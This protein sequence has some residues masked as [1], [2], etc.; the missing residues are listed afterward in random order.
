[1]C[2]PGSFSRPALVGGD[3][4]LGRGDK[5]R[6]RVEGVHYTGWLR[7]V[8]KLGREEEFAK[9]VSM[10]PSV[11]F[12][13]H[14]LD[15]RIEFYGF[16]RGIAVPVLQ[17]RASV[18]PVEEPPEL[19]QKYIAEL[20]P[21]RGDSWETG[22]TVSEAWLS[23]YSML[24]PGEALQVVAHYDSRTHRELRRRPATIG[25]GSDPSSRAWDPSSTTGGT[26]TG[27]GPSRSSAGSASTSSLYASSAMT[28]SG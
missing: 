10:S 24:E 4:G 18:R 7:I 28:R 16:L 19:G 23:V 12:E 27:P 6:S 5:L 14:R 8:P 9:L 2:P 25:S 17:R 1:M 15:D 13:A 22:F 20:R 3:P 21:P 26:R 11:V